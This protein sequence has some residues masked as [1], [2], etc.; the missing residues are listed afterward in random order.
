MCL[1]STSPGHTTT[2]II[3]LKQREVTGVQTTE[4]LSSSSYLI[5]VVTHSVQLDCIINIFLEFHHYDAYILIFMF[6]I[7]LI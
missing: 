4:H 5:I 3:T 7:H 2:L 1:A 6:D